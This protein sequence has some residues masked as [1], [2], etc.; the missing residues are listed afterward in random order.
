[1]LPVSDNLME[2]SCRG[3]SK[4]V[5]LHYS[6]KNYGCI[7]LGSQKATETKQGSHMLVLRPNTRGIPDI[8]V[9]SIHIFMWSSGP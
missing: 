3:I 8:I 9:C 4:P 2:G 6:L 7:D 1:M 5:P